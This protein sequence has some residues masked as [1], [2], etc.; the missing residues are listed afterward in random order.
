LFVFF[1]YT[2]QKKKIQYI[3]LIYR[4]YI[5]V[6]L[7]MVNESD[8]SDAK[9]S[10][11][12]LDIAQSADLRPE[13]R[14]IPVPTAPAA[15]PAA[16]PARTLIRFYMISALVVVLVV[17][18]GYYIKFQ[19]KDGFTGNVLKNA[20]SLFSSTRSK[21]N[22]GGVAT[23]ALNSGGVAA[24]ALVESVANTLPGQGSAKSGHPEVVRLSNYINDLQDL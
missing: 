7:A 11:A 8:T 17:L 23:N 18:V 24:N 22:S 15:P 14:S 10:G 5:D 21:L 2:T 16:P 20:S 6:I 3:P 13:V 9:V 4:V 19:G 1:F 12:P